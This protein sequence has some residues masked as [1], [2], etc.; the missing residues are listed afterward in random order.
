MTKYKLFNGKKYSEYLASQTPRQA[1]I[2]ANA[3]R[4]Q[5]YL[6]RVT[7]RQTRL[8]TPSGKVS[9]LKEWVTW[10]YKTSKSKGKIKC[11]ECNSTNV[12]LFRKYSDDYKA[13]MCKGC[14]TLF[15]HDTR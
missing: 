10:I 4:E 15:Y 7:T 2:D 3:K 9:K 8:I 12:D 6:V 11:V 5:G 13:Y 14:G 1:Q